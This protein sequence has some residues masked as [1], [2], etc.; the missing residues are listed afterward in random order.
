MLL[1]IKR[2][3]FIMI[4]GPIHQKDIIIINKYALNNI[5]PIYMKE[6]LTEMKREID[7]T[8]I[9]LHFQ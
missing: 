4:K 6:N 5:D 9:I 8:T 7:K 3:H 1:E 2:G